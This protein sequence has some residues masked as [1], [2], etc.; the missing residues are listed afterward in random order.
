[1]IAAGLR[2]KLT[3]VDLKQLSVTFVG[4]EFDIALL[5][6]LPTE[7]D[8][9]GERGE[10]HTCVYAGPIKASVAL[11]AGEM[12]TR[13]SFASTGCRLAKTQEP[14]TLFENVGVKDYDALPNR[15]SRPSPSARLAVSVFWRMGS[16][17][18]NQ[19]SCRRVSPTLMRTVASSETPHC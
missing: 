9:C 5:K 1:M 14:G 7:T 15:S 6:D 18:L 2:A 3:C 16:A 8:P 13:D 17:D 10:F 4:R 11:E 19:C 12:V